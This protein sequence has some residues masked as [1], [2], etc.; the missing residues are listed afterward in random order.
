M[1]LKPGFRDLENVSLS[2]NR[3]VP[4]I[5]VIDTKIVG[6]FPGTN[7]VLNRVYHFAKVCLKQCTCPLS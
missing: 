6:V 2:L 7:F 3:S 4:A 1:E 5:E